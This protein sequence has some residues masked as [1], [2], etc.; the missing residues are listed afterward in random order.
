MPSYTPSH[1]IVVKGRYMRC[2]TNDEQK[3]KELEEE[4]N[5]LVDT[6]ESYVGGSRGW[7]GPEISEVYIDETRYTFHND[8]TYPILAEKILTM[9]QE[10]AQ[11]MKATEKTGG[12]SEEIL[13][14]SQKATEETGETGGGSKEPN[15]KTTIFKKCTEEGA[16]EKHGPSQ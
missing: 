3:K 6:T 8:G 2:K 1:T 7:G 13:T 9:L 12:R 10:A 4:I 15:K 5:A 11:N 14:I 16:G